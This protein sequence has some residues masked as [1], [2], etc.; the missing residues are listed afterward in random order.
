MGLIEY[1]ALCATLYIEGDPEV[2]GLRY[3]IQKNMYPLVEKWFS[4]KG[5][6]HETQQKC[7]SKS[8]S[9]ALGSFKV[10]LEWMNVEK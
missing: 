3:D 6:T 5:V 7:S 8:I 4:D 2:Y 1:K 10:T 9:F